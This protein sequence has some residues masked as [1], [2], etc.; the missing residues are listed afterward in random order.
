M[1]AHEEMIYFSV[2]YERF[3]EKIVTFMAECLKRSN[4]KHSLLMMMSW[5]NLEKNIKLK[6]K[7]AFSQI[8]TLIS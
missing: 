2:S 3:S 5:R 7:P 1:L 6:R 4:W 8:S